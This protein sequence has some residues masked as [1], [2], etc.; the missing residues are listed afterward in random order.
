MPQISYFFGIVVFMYYDEHNPPH[1]H[2]VY[3]GYKATYE[4]KSGKRSTGQMSKTADK[5]LK[6]WIGLQRTA[7]LKTWAL[8]KKHVSPLP[9]V[10]PLE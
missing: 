4:I 1:I 5:L 6:K 2:A 3:G 7:L 10:E 9:S 8:A